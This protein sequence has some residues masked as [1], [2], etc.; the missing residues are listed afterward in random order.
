MH[1]PVLL[2]ELLALFADRSIRRFVDG[3]LGAGGHAEALLQE[4]PEIEQFIGCD[5]DLQALAIAKERLKPWQDKLLLFHTRSDAIW[6]KLPL[7]FASS[8][9]GVLLDLGVSSMQLDWP[10]RG[11]SFS[12]TGPL[13]MRMNQT[14]ALTAEKI[15]NTWSEKELGRIFR[16]WGE[17]PKWRLAARLLDLLG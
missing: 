2:K 1:Q 7:D 10:D 13:D 6:E 16:E 17:E 8:I 15:V 3:T 5:Q 11:F 14:Q 9:D 12:N 4:H